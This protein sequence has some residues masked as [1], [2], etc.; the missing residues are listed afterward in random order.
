[1]RRS[2]RYV[3]LPEITKWD[4]IGGGFLS[5]ENEE[6]PSLLFET[7]KKR[8][9]D[10]KPRKVPVAG[11]VF[12]YGEYDLKFRVK[13]Y[14]WFASFEWDNLYKHIV[15]LP[16][17]VIKTTHYGRREWVRPRR[18]R[19]WYNFT[20]FSDYEYKPYKHVRW[21]GE[22]VYTG[23][24]KWLRFGLK[25]FLILAGIAAGFALLMWLVWVFGLFVILFVWFFEAIF[26]I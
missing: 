22:R 8:W 26:G 2:Y 5:K 1:M 18:W 4:L 13:K 14:G 23:W 15:P 17:Q 11:Q 24:R 25:W 7:R 10:R 3:T 12:T 19:W 21:Y 20:E 16:G 9:F 6:Y